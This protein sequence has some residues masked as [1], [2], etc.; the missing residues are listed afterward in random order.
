MLILL[1]YDRR[2]HR[3]LRPGMAPRRLRARRAQHPLHRRPPPRGSDPQRAGE[4]GGRAPAHARPGLLRER[5][6]R[7][8]HGRALPRPR[9]QRRSPRRLQPRR[10]APR[11]PTPPAGRRVADPLRRRPVQRRARHPLHRHHAAAASH[12]E[13]GG[14]PAAAG[15]RPA[16]VA[17]HRQELSHGARPENATSIG[18]QHRRFRFDLRY[19]ALLGCSRRQLQD[20][21][22]AGFPFLPPGCR[23]VLDRVASDHVLANL[24]QCLPSRRP[25]L[26]QELRSLAAAGE[27]TPASDLAAWLEAL[28]MDPAHF[29]GIR[30]V[31]FTALRRELGWLS[32]APHPEEERLSRGIGSALLHGDDPDRLRALAAALSAPATPE[33]QTLGER[34]RRAWLMLTVQ[35]FGTGRQWRPLD[36]A[37][38][39][40]WQA[41]AWR[42]E[43]RQLLELLAAR[44]DHRLHPLPWALPVPLRVHGHY[45][46]AEIEAAFGVLSD[47]APW[48]HRE[49]VL[50]HEPSRCDLLFVTLRKSEALFSPTTRYRDL[51]LGPSLFHWESQ[52]TTTAASATGQ[53]YVHHQ[54]RG[55]RV[56]LFVREKRKQGGVTEP[57]VCLG[58]A[59][60]ES[61][62][63][64]GF[65][66][67]VG[68]RP[69]A[70]RWRLRRRFR[71][72]G[73]R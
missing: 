37:L 4:E 46:R 41:G 31:S 6:A 3:S 64:E 45:S 20:Q 53:R 48:I 70:I 30:G 13:R 73:Y 54:A 51:A 8:L 40:L 63:A 7:P 52:S 55:S 35:L 29:Y 44:A 10:S 17:R 61:Y 26:L 59:R 38:A 57:F 27:I 68:E 2:R 62:V 9:L 15:P 18:Q 1:L 66:A 58:F 72:G 14:V 42:Q 36:D 65:C 22:A 69:M 16:S 12:R 49:G 23:L 24:R 47:H 60:Y 19:R 28:A 43:L 71:R 32:D 11:G 25:Q 33:L 21:L 34:E 39:V 67:A 56:L 5:G 50:W